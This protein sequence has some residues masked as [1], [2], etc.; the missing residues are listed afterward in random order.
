M[1]QLVKKHFNTLVSEYLNKEYIKLECEKIFFQEQ[2]NLK[3]AII[4]AT[5]SKKCF[6]KKH[7]HQQRIPNT[8]LKNFKNKVLGQINRIKG[9]QTFEELFVIIQS[10]KIFGIGILT[11]YDVSLRIGFY[12][13]IF[14]EK[15]YLQ[16]GSK[17]GYQN[18]IGG[19]II[20]EYEVENYINHKNISYYHFENFLCLYRDQFIETYIETKRKV[21]CS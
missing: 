17:I 21:S 12:L 15:L 2:S 19:Q 3:D 20:S 18:L 5:I 4:F 13:A 14:P 1:N 11:I 6:G 7:N 9:V 10:C 8:V 16:A